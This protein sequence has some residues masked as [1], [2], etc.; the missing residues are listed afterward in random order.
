MILMMFALYLAAHLTTRTIS[1]LGH[2]SAP[3]QAWPERLPMRGMRSWLV[4]AGTD[5]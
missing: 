3:T 4:S 1:F 5:I 2:L